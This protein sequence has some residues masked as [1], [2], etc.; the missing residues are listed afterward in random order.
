L[1][2][3][4]EKEKPVTIRGE[5]KTILSIFISSNKLTLTVSRKGET[6]F[7]RIDRYVIPLDYLLFKIFEKNID[8]LSTVCELAEKVERKEIVEEAG[9]E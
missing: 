2:E 9:P 1:S 8:A 3:K 6:G 7:E 5:N 4:S